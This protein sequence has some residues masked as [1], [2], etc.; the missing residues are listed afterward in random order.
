M[1]EAAV[2]ADIALEKVS[3][4]GVLAK[5]TSIAVDKIAKEA[6][7]LRNNATA[8]NSE[9]ED[10]SYRVEET[11]DKLNQ[12]FE[13]TKTNSSLI[14]AAKEAVSMISAYVHFLQFTFS[15]YC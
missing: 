3:Q 2:N 9:A 11:E 5:N 8:L 10:M 7:L 6:E 1:T 4:A 13:L 15:L 14:N 12:F